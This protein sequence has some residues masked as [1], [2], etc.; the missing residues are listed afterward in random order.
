MS[1]NGEEDKQLPF[2]RILVPYNGSEQS[3]LALNM[4]I[5][6]AKMSDGAKLFI[7]YVLDQIPVPPFFSR[8]IRVSMASRPKLIVD[9]FDEVYQQLE[10]NAKDS[11]KH[12]EDKCEKKG[13]DTKIRVIIG[14]PVRKIVEVAEKEKIDLIV[15]G[16]RDSDARTKERT[17]RIAKK[18]LLMN[19]GSVS[20]SVAE[21]SPC[22]VLLLRP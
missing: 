8:P 7:L 10:V 2:K 4:A 1:I 11:L 3:N 17:K 16:S 22:P 19:L 13:I 20:R 6:L 14:E 21:R 15:L 12:I 5:N 9:Y 18:L